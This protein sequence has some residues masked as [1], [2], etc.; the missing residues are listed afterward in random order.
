MADLRIETLE[1]QD[2]P[3]PSIEYMVRLAGLTADLHRKSR[4]LMF[5]RET[6][7][8]PW[9][10]DLLKTL[11]YLVSNDC[12]TEDYKNGLRRFLT[13]LTLVFQRGSWF[14]RERD[15]FRSIFTTTWQKI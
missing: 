6:T 2:A 7:G 8:H 9:C 4:V 14:K 13:E 12:D 3:Q 10:N 1:T 15:Q 11:D 5:L